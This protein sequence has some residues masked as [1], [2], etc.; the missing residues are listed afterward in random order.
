MNFIS[1]LVAL[2]NLLRVASRPTINPVDA[3]FTE[4]EAFVMTSDG[5]G[6]D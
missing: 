3:V 6:H 5:N 4:R 2:L 1:F